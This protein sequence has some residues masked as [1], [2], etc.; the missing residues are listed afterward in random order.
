MKHSVFVLASIKPLD[1]LVK[2]QT[3]SCETSVT[4]TV[5]AGLCLGE[6]IHLTDL[7]VEHNHAFRR[8]YFPAPASLTQKLDGID[9]VLVLEFPAH[10]VQS[11]GRS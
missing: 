4:L 1:Y 5:R 10:A 7:L 9:H 6:H 3:A 8:R 2:I 11:D